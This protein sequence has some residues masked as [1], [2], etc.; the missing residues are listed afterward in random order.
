MGVW[1][2]AEK[3]VTYADGFFYYYGMKDVA[4]NSHAA[5][6]FKMVNDDG[7]TSTSCAFKPGYHYYE[8][9]PADGGVFTSMT[10]IWLPGY[11]G[12][13]QVCFDQIAFIY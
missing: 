13:A 10:H 11:Q 6:Y 7:T 3:A 9:V 1:I 4:G 5:A 2:Y 8:F 12:K